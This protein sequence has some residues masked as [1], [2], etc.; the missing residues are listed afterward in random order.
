[1]SA[2]CGAKTAAVADKLL[3]SNQNRRPPGEVG[4]RYRQSA[5]LHKVIEVLSGQLVEAQ[6]ANILG[7]MLLSPQVIRQEKCEEGKKEGDLPRH[8]VDEKE[9]QEGAADLEGPEQ[10]CQERQGDT[11]QD[12]AQGHCLH[13][14]GGVSVPL[15]GRHA[16]R[17]CPPAIGRPRWTASGVWRRR[18]GWPDRSER[19]AGR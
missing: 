2:S 14:A 6:S 10:A 15:P 18:R 11:Y 4:R 16:F 13:S 8:G 12:A 5:D 9:L 1:M 3:F 17:G 19:G 7:G